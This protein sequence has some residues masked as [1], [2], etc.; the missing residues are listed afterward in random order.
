MTLTSL[1]ILKINLN[2]NR[3][4]VFSDEEL[5]N[6]LA[7]NDNDVLKASWRGCLMKAN[8]DKKIKVG[9]IEVENA[10][11]DYWNNLAAMY[12]ADY[13]QEQANVN[14]S[15]ATGYKTSM[16]RADGC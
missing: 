5:N 4:P 1:E 6:L 12:Q 9:P 2:E 13:L 7:V 3:Y 11:P 16:R 10:D 14:P 15:K 8:T